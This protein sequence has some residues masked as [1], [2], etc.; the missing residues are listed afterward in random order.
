MVFRKLDELQPVASARPNSRQCACTG[1]NNMD[2]L[3]IKKILIVISKVIKSALR[4]QHRSHGEGGKLVRTQDSSAMRIQA[5]I[6][7]LKTRPRV[8]RNTS[9]PWNLLLL[10]AS[11]NYF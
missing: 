3:A 8:S 4:Q 9:V 10:R 2:D 1:I 11:G 5:P 7:K 6:K